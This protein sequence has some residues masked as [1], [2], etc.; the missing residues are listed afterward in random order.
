MLLLTDPLRL[1]TAIM[2]L[3]PSS[4]SFQDRLATAR[5][6]LSTFWSPYGGENNKHKKRRRFDSL[7]VRSPPV[8]DTKFTEAEN[9]SVVVD[10]VQIAIVTY[11]GATNI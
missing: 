6:S 10:V 7:L 8:R 9:E 1:Q 4:K 3:G 2:S 11:V 5:A